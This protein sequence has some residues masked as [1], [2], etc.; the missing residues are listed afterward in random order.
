MFVIEK[1]SVPIIGSSV[2]TRKPMA[3]GEMKSVSP[4]R[5]ATLQG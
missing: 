3:Q 2:K 4:E 1:T 5:L